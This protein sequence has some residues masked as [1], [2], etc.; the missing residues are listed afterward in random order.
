MRKGRPRKEKNPSCKKPGCDRPAAKGQAYCC[1]EHAPYGH[2][3]I[4]EPDQK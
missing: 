4:D 1:R 2:Y 3:G